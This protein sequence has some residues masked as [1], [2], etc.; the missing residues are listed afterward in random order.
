MNEEFPN[1][2]EFY[3]SDAHVFLSLKYVSDVTRIWISAW[4]NF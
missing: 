1:C 2:R 3:A 4:L